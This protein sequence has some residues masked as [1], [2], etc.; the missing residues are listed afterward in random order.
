MIVGVGVLKF[1]HTLCLTEAVKL[2]RAKRR[3]PSLR[4]ILLT[5]TR[6]MFQFLS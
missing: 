6:R 4:Y 1:E 5:Q 2:A 3:A